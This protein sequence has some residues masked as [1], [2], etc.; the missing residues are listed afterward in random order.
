MRDKTIFIV[1]LLAVI[2]LL[3]GCA[4]T[5]KY[6]FESRTSEFVYT[7]LDAELRPKDLEGGIALQFNDDG[8]KLEAGR[9][10][11]ADEPIVDIVKAALPAAMCVANPLL[12]P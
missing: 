9:T 7:K 4:S 12:C 5:S 2:A 11:T 10:I 8:L 1:P 6:H 3:S